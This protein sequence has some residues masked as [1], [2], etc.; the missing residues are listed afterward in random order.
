M[1]TLLFTS[2]V[3]AIT[4]TASVASA[5]RCSIKNETKYSFTISS[6]NTSNQRVG[7]HT[8]TSI[9]S[10]EIIAKADGEKKSVGGACAAGSKIK[11]VEKKDVLMILPQ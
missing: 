9:A 5:G 3:C 2:V 11:I 7:S 10:G 8:S 4:L 6:G 1:R